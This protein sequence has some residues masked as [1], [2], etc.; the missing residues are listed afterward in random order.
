MIKWP[1]PKNISELRS[2]L[3]LTGYYHKFVQNYSGIASP[4]TELLKKDK[5]YTWSTFCQE[6]F[7][8]LKKRL[9]SAP[10]LCNPDPKLK[11]TLTTDA[12]GYAMGTVLSQDDGQG[13]RPV[14]F[15][16]CK[17]SPAEKNYA[18][19]EKELLAII[20]ALKIWKHYL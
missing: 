6:A 5:P 17:F 2:F 18:I 16:S 1:K 3:G 15:E 8:E 9:T 19:Y 4:L 7:Q 10:I 11:F 13:P 20:H 12:S 14:A